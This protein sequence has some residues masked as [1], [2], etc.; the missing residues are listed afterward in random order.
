MARRNRRN[1]NVNYG[2]RN[3]RTNRDYIA[4]VSQSKLVGIWTGKE[5]ESTYIPAPNDRDTR[6]GAMQLLDEVLDRIP[7][8]DEL[9]DKQV[10]IYS[11]DCLADCMLKPGDVIRSEAVSAEAKE[12]IPA[13]L[14]KL[15]DRSFNCFIM[16]ESGSN[17]TIVS[18]GFEWLKDEAE[19]KVG[20]AMGV[21]YEKKSAKV[22]AV[23]EHKSPLQVQEDKLN[24]AYDELDEAYDND[25]EEKASKLESK[26]ARL[27]ARIAEMKAEQTVKA[28]A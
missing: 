22:P 4:I 12:M 28:Q 16:R 7:T 11:L 8:N 18:E 25:D 15:A 27:K 2:V 5:E 24:Q 13:L 20:E 21:H 14:Q 26:I 19:R 10:V 6:L 3:N 17:A 23:A 1:N 9:L